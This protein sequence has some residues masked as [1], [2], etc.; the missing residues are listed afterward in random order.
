MDNV[1]IIVQ[2]TITEVTVSVASLGIK[3]EKGDDSFRLR[4]LFTVTELLENIII[5]PQIPKSPNTVLVTVNGTT[6]QYGRDFT[7]VG[8]IWTWVS[9]LFTLQK[10][11]DIAIYY[12]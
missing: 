4:H 6:Y 11:F 7:I 3:G 10:G 5:L 12:N 2:P 1:S 8:S 9:P